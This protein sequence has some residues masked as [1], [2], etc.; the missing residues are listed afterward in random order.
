MDCK[1]WIRLSTPEIV[2]IGIDLE[3]PWQEWDASAAQVLV[4]LRPLPEGGPGFG[5]GG[6]QLQEGQSVARRVGCWLGARLSPSKGLHMFPGSECKSRW[7]LLRL[8]QGRSLRRTA[9][10]SGAWTLALAAP[11]KGGKVGGKQNHSKMLL[12]SSLAPHRPRVTRY[13][14]VWKKTQ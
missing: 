1:G 14:S 9:T 3:L 5:A 11:R 10:G 7:V 12:S 13:C 4:L 2:P 8:G 6:G